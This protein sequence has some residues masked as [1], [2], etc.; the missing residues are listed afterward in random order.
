MARFNGDGDDS[1]QD[2]DA[3]SDDGF[4]DGLDDDCDD[5]DARDDG[6]D[7]DNVYDGHVLMMVMNYGATFN[8]H[9]AV[10]C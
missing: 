8:A 9:A 3:S 10:E 5:G 2:D 4:A 6:D 1:D 7:S